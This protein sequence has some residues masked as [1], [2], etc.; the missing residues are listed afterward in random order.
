MGKKKDKTNKSEKTVLSNALEIDYDKLADAIV[1]AQI[2]AKE[3]EQKI[4][5]EKKAQENEAWRRQFGYE[6]GK[7][8]T[9]ITSFARLLFVKKK[10]IKGDRATFALLQMSAEL[11]L[12]IAKWALYLF[13]AGCLLVPFYAYCTKQP[14]SVG[15]TITGVLMGILAFIYAR[16]LRIAEIEIDNLTDREYLNTIIAS[17]TALI[18]M[19]VSIISISK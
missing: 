15:E 4:Q 3:K 5:E 6:E 16:M 13:F 19:V 8:G 7:P 2:I 9:R 12:A 11:I 14:L 18:A 17:I 1:K 10:D